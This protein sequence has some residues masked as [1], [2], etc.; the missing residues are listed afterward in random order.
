MC[1][2]TQMI[3]TAAPQ[4]AAARSQVA[5]P[6]VNRMSSESLL[7]EP[8]ASRLVHAGQIGVDNSRRRR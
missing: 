3:V 7:T 6:R 2:Q 8:F 5:R 4:P 1:L